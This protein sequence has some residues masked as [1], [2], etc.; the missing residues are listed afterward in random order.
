MSPI[1]N[2]SNSNELRISSSILSMTRLE[3]TGESGLPIGVPKSCRYV[4]SLYEKKQ[5]SKTLSKHSLK[6]FNGKDVCFEIILHFSDTQSI[7][8][9]EST[10]VKSDL[11]SREIKTVCWF[12]FKRYRIVKFNLIEFFP[13]QL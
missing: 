12:F 10:L 1:K 7:I 2:G 13:F 6:S 9:L 4:T 8:N 11:T 5:L 3:T